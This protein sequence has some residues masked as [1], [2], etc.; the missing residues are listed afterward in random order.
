[1]TAKELQLA[2]LSLGQAKILG[3]Y[4]WAYPAE[5]IPS[6][7]PNGFCAH[8]LAKGV[9]AG[10]WTLDAIR[11]AVPFTPPPVSAADAVKLDAIVAVANRAESISLEVKGEVADALRR[12]KDAVIIAGTVTNHV[13]T[14]L[15]AMKD[16]IDAYVER[17]VQID[18]G[19]I[20]AEVGRL[21][22]KEF[23]PFKQAVADAGAETIVAD[24]S[25]VHITDRRSALDVFGI[26]ICERN[27]DQVM[28][29]IWNHPAAPAIDPHWVWTEKI[30]RAILGV[31]GT[32]DNLF[33]GGAK[34][35]GKSQTAEQ[36]AAYTGRAYVRFQFTKY[37]T[38]MD[39]MGG[40]GMSAGSTVFEKGAVLAGL[41]S[42][43]TVVLLDELSMTD[44][45][46]LAILNGFL[47]LNPVISYGGAVHRRANGVLVFGADNTLTN[48]DDSGLYG[49]TRRLN[50]ATAERFCSVI[51]FEH[52]SQAMEVDIVCRRTGCSKALATH[53]VKALGAFRAKVSSGDII[54]APSIRQTMY[55][56][57][58]LRLMTVDDAWDAA[59]GNRQPSESAIAVHAIKTACIS[60]DFIEKNL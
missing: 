5:V 1:M 42:P 58:N 31:Q 22:A 16:R 55:F 49:G 14:T 50:T 20:S 9:L 8:A 33:F 60:A 27:G 19:T 34:G 54:D 13:D 45:G 38:A 30:L 43:S 15:T 6:V 37:T 32:H 48:G 57:K 47:E 41:T 4:K 35:T 59:I 36:F 10:L 29:D 53:V 11:N 2:I 52:M 17:P 12:A 28:V 23:A 25:G 21:I 46:E 40:K 18:A 7:N 44:A 24:L 26:D 39:F 3:A 56:I 51:K